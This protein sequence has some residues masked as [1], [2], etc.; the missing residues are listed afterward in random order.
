LSE[1]KSVYNSAFFDQQ[2]EV[3]W[4]IGIFGVAVKVR[5]E[6]DA[7]RRHPGDRFSYFPF[8]LDKNVIF[9]SFHKRERTS[10]THGSIPAL[11]CLSS[12]EAF[13]ATSL[14]CSSASKPPWQAVCDSDM[15]LHELQRRS[16]HAPKL[17]A[18]IIV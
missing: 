1:K 8:T 2:F 4:L 14:R 12:K 3:I 9:F 11:F 15:C 5:C 7:P 10:D 6:I 16:L 17:T 18:A 13:T